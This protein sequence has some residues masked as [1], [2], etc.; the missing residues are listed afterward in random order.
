MQIEREVLGGP[1]VASIPSEGLVEIGLAMADRAST[2]RPVL[3]LL[4]KPS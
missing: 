4:P 1:H 3:R 2:K